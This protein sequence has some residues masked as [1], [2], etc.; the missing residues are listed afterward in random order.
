MK[1]Y[2]AYKDSGVDLIGKIPINW[3]VVKIKRITQFY[4][5]QS[6]SS[7]IYFYK[8]KYITNI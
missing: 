2:P 6:L 5:G 4:Y 1:R 3:D 7:G 8:M